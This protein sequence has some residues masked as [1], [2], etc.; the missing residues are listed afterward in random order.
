MLGSEAKYGALPPS[1]GTGVSGKPAPQPSRPGLS[2]QSEAGNGGP[3]QALLQFPVPQG[4]LLWTGLRRPLAHSPWVWTARPLPPSL[5]PCWAG[6]WPRRWGA[7]G[8]AEPQ[9]GPPLHSGPPSWAVVSAGPGASGM[10]SPGPIFRSWSVEATAHNTVPSGGP[11][12]DSP[13]T[14]VSQALQCRHR[15][16]GAAM[17]PHSVPEAPGPRSPEGEGPQASVLRQQGR[18]TPGLTNPNCPHPC[19][20]VVTRL[21]TLRKLCPPSAEVPETLP[22]RE[23]LPVPPTQSA[24][25]SAHHGASLCPQCPKDLLPFTLRKRPSETPLGPRKLSPHLPSHVAL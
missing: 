9:L 2:G 1:E 24:A 21:S 6:R 8:V 20:D 16:A 25:P 22:V 23:G 17:Q 7:G 11:P 3:A 18:P 19:P 12:G 14:G 15:P 13:P 5:S 4:G 10:Q